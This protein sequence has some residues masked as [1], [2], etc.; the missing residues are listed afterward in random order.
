MKLYKLNTTLITENL[1]INTSNISTNLS[2]FQNPYYFV[3]TAELLNGKVHRAFA[4]AR[5]EFQNN[6]VCLNYQTQLV[7]FEEMNDFLQL[8]S[9]RIVLAA[10]KNPALL[11]ENGY[12]SYKRYPPLDPINEPNIG[13]IEVNIFCPYSLTGSLLVEAIGDQCH[14]NFPKT[15]NRLV[16]SPSY[17]NICTTSWSDRTLVLG[18]NNGTWNL[19]GINPTERIRF[20]PALKKQLLADLEKGPKSA[21]NTK[22]QKR[23]SETKSV[24][25]PAVVDQSTEPTRLFW[26]S[27][28]GWKESH[29]VAKLVDSNLPAKNSI[30]PKP[31]GKNKRKTNPHNGE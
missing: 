21:P 30:D 23:T 4:M 22:R 29:S 17:L 20:Q 6:N 18:R 5:E 2:G 24:Q 28:P 10:A 9:T 12:V 16:Y 31:V 3:C 13:A 15:T 27:L 11:A 8:E 19:R 7:P 14:R 25:K 26:P 1:M